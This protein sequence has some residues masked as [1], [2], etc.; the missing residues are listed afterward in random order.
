MDTEQSRNDFFLPT[1]SRYA[2]VGSNGLP[3]HVQLGLTPSKGFLKEKDVW[4]NYR[5]NYF[6]VSCHVARLSPHG[7]GSSKL[8]VDQ[9]NQVAS[10]HLDVSA[11]YCDGSDAGLIQFTSQRNK[12]PKATPT[13]QLVPLHTGA[14][15]VFF[16]RLQF[17]RAT[18]NNS[19]RIGV[20]KPCRIIIQLTVKTTHGTT[21]RIA[22]SV[23][24]PILVRGRSPA[25]FL[26][27][28]A[29]N[30]PMPE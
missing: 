28:A 26:K 20:K 24:Q 13:P 27:L 17:N 7:P 15:R 12:G 25:H 5:R 4:L 2:L 1:E 10:F 11:E 6:E 18:P 22:E 8:Y 29:N 30:H 9:Q 23:S 14:T 3:I 16:K 21:I 19:R